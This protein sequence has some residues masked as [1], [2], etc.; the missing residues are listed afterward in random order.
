[1]KYLITGLGNPGEEYAHT[2]HNIGFDVL[3]SFAGSQKL[4]FH[5]ARLGA[6]AECKV[7]GRIMLLLK[8]STFVNLSGKA[9]KYWM[10]KEKIPLENL[11][12]IMDE[13]ALPLSVL[14]LRASGSDSGHN[15]LKSIAETLLTQDYARL[16]FGIGKN[17]PR[18]G[19]VEYVLGK[20]KSDEIPVVQKKIQ[21]SVKTIEDFIFTGV[22]AAM[23]SVNHLVFD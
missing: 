1:M 8:P 9:V 4:D 7:K 16:R 17:Y 19:Q 2:R 13:L 5:S 15:G 12:V 20:W 3:D 22:Q 14:R 6:V 23:N 11:L 21:Q 18:G 10:D